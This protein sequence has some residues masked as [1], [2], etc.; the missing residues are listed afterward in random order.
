MPA[1]GTTKPNTAKDAVDHWVSQLHQLFRA[2]EATANSAGWG[3]TMS[4]TDIR[5]DP[6]GLGAPLEYEAPV[7]V[8]KRPDPR[9]GDEQRITFEPRQRYA[10]GA[11]GRID[12]Y[13][14]PRLREALLL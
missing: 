14:Y 3:A 10:P 8:L 5:E 6:F 2:V 1:D 4:S 9:T 11:A 13:S 7:L 12:I